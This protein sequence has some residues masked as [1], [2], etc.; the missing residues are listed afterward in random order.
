MADLIID[1][2][3][4]FDEDQQKRGINV[5]FRWAPTID[6]FLSMFCISNTLVECYLVHMVF[7]RATLPPETP[8][9]DMSRS[10]LH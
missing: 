6:I 8:I 9:R 4:C 5:L 2:Y 10:V 3:D 7:P 1:K